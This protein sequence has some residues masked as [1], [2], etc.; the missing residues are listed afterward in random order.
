MKCF[1]SAVGPYANNLKFSLNFNVNFHN[2]ML[3]SS[4]FSS[5]DPMLVSVRRTHGM[6]RIVQYK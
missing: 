3:K 1:E 5:W 6:L 4:S 2:E